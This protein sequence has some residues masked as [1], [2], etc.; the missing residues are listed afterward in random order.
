MKANSNQV[1]RCSI[2]Q[3]LVEMLFRHHET[4]LHTHRDWLRQVAARLWGDQNCCTL[5]VRIQSSIK[6]FAEA[7]QYLVQVAVPL[8][9]KPAPSLPCVQHEQSVHVMVTDP[10]NQKATSPPPRERKTQQFLG[11]HETNTSPKLALVHSP[12]ASYHLGCWHP[13]WDPI[14]E[15]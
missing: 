2:L 11:M 10:P 14:P 7:Q 13:T 3:V 9:R 4:A 1:K 8:H 5:P 15:S 12:N 6:H